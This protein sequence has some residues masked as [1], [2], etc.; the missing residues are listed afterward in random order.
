M[1]ELKIDK[2]IEAQVEVM[3]TLGQQMRELKDRYPNCFSLL[4][5]QFGFGDYS[6]DNSPDNIDNFQ[7]RLYAEIIRQHNIND[8]KKA[9]RVAKELMK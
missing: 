9:R 2:K 3:F 7:L 5:Q 4:K 1:K 6:S 8:S